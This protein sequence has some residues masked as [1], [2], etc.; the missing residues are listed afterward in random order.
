MKPFI[1]PSLWAF[2][3]TV[4][5]LTM[6]LYGTDRPPR[7]TNTGHAV[8]ADTIRP[9]TKENHSLNTVYLLPF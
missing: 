1:K 4:L 8:P 2:A 9:L 7:R 6:G 5:L 3:L